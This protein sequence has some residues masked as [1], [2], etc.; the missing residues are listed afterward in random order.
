[1]HNEL[2]FSKLKSIFKEIKKENIDDKL[3]DILDV[4]YF[5]NDSRFVN[6]F[7]LLFISQIQKPFYK[8]FYKQMDKKTKKEIFKMIR[9]NYPRYNNKN[10]FEVFYNYAVSSTL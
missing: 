4:Y 9:T 2:D 3:N 8:T 6:R 7:Q 5:R 1:M 10:N